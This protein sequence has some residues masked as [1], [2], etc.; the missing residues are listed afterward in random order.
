VTAEEFKVVVDPTA[1][2][3]NIE[4]STCDDCLSAF[5]NVVRRH[6][7]VSDASIFMERVR[8]REA[9][10]STATVDRVAFPHARTDAVSRLFLAVG[11]SE[12]GVV[13][14]PE[15]PPVHLVFLIGAPAAAI[16]DY[17]ACVAWLARR[18]RDPE[19]RKAVLLAGTPERLLKSIAAA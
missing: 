12:T 9:A 13:F 16:A 7:A 2:L 17:L 19:I 4:A 5:E 11:R 1:V 8:A 3:M 14:R 10:V 6:S 15:L 18:V